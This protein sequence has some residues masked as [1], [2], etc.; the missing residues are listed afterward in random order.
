MKKYLVSYEHLVINTVVVT[1]YAESEAEAIEKA[2]RGDTEG[3]E[4]VID[5]DGVSIANYEAS[6]QDD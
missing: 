5:E 1:V 6:E 3:D 4:E 2:K